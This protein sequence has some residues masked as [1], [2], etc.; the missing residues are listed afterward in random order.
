MIDAE[1]QAA[2]TEGR[3]PY[4]IGKMVHVPVAHGAGF[5]AG[6]I[7]HLHPDGRVDV[8]VWHRGG[9]SEPRDEVVLLGQ[10]PDPRWPAAPNVAWWPPEL[11]ALG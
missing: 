7:T 9:G 6:I 3:A 10:R 8:T 11:E 1:L 4:L 5:A 2:V